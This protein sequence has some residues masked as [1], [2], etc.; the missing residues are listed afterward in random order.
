VSPPCTRID[1]G[2]DIARIDAGGQ[3]MHPFTQNATQ[4]RTRSQKPLKTPIPALKYPS[5]RSGIIVFF[6]AW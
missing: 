4:K 3:N 1:A 5:L 2:A 6:L